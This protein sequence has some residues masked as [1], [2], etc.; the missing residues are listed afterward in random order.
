MALRGGEN[1][2]IHTPAPVTLPALKLPDVDAV[3]RREVAIEIARRKIIRAARDAWQTANKASSFEALKIIGA[4]L[5]IGRDHALR[6]TA[7]SAEGHYNRRLGVAYRARMR[8]YGFGTMS[9]ETRKHILVLTENAAAIERWRSSLPEKERNRMGN[10]QHIV[11]RWRASLN[12][13]N[14]K[15]PQDFKRD[16]VAAWR[17]FCFMRR[18]AAAR[19]S[20]AAMASR[21]RASGGGI[22]SWLRQ[23]KVKSITHA[24][25]PVLIATRCSTTTK[26]IARYF[27]PPLSP[28]SNLGQCVCWGQ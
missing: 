12:H 9:N 8:A 13:G 14:G 20:A 15:C 11:R 26:P 5:L 7:A 17:R 28:A 21:A 25:M 1:F 10:A 19:S 22:G 24:A 27:I 16:A 23:A 3:E 2:H 18:N 4:A 6:V